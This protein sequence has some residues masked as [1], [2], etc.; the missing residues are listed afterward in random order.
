MKCTGMP[1][2]ILSLGLE[3]NFPNGELFHLAGVTGTI[4]DRATADGATADG[5]GAVGVS[6]RAI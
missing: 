4:A 6:A 2:P 3:H 1:Y 5:A